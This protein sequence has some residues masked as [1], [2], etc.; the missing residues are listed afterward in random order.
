MGSELRIIAPGKTQ[1]AETIYD[2]SGKSF[3]FDSYWGW[4]DYCRLGYIANS[5]YDWNTSRIG[6]VGDKVVTHFGVWD[7][8]MR[9]GTGRVRTAGIGAVCTDGR[10]RKRGLM[11]QTAREA[12][13]AM[14]RG[15]YDMSVLFGL[16]D[17]YHRFGYVRAWNYTSYIVAAEEMQRYMPSGKCAIK[18][19][20]FA[21]MSRQD[22]DVL[23][24]RQFSKYVGTAVRPTFMANR[25]KVRGRTSSYLWSGPSGETVGYVIVRQHRQSLTCL[26]AVGD[27]QAVLAALAMLCRRRRA[28]ELKFSGLPYD[29]EVAVL[30]RRGTCRMETRL[31]R[32]GG[33]MIR[34]VSL[35]GILG[36]ITGELSRRLRESHMRHWRGRLLISDENDR[37]A[38]TIGRGKVEMAGSI[39]GRYKHAIRGGWELAQ[40]IIGTDSP[41]ETTAAAG[42]KLTGDGEALVGV[43]FGQKHPNLSEWDRF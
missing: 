26:E 9:I 3:D 40:L 36:K 39:T 4:Q 18:L 21:W 34:T 38:L 37:V 29:H 7:Y 35:P 20:K 16:R 41:A 10:F 17:F 15:G 43:L 32:S 12:V 25:W 27:G 22:L 13:A 24:N 1:H 23:Y 28:T 19:Q 33:A 6:L 31:T 11:A 14:Q 8:Q 2:L 5:H 30:L 42:T